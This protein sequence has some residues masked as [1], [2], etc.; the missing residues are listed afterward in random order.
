MATF[1]FEGIDEFV[2]QL[3]KI[4]GKSEEI[5]GKAI[6]DGAAVVM[7]YVIMGIDSIVTDNRFGTQENP[8]NGP[9]SYE[10]EGLYRSVGIAKARHDGTFFNVKIG[11]DGYD[12]IQTKKWPNGRPHSMIAR[13]IE[14]GTSYMKK[15]PFMRKAEQAARAP[16]ERAMQAALDRAI[17]QLTK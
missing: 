6:Y 15:Q 9:S 14:S 4:Y 1:Q 17:E 12:D 3:E 13:S 8:C 5:E 11:F 10:K 2:S 16:C 7:R